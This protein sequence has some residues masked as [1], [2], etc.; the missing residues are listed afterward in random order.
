MPQSDGIQLDLFTN[1]AQDESTNNIKAIDDWITPQRD[2][3][4]RIANIQ[5]QRKRSVTCKITLNLAEN[6]RSEIK[7]KLGDDAEFTI[8]TE[9]L[10]RQINGVYWLANGARL[11]LINEDGALINFVAADIEFVASRYGNVTDDAELNRLAEVVAS[12]KNL[13]ESKKEKFIGTI[14]KISEKKIINH[15]K[16]YNQRTQLKIEIDMFA[17]E[18]Y[19]S[20]HADY[21]TVHFTHLD[22]QT[23]LRSYNNE[24]IDDYKSHFKELD[25]VLS[26]IIASRF[27]TDRKKSFLWL[28]CDSDWGK[29]LLISMLSSIGMLTTTST[30]EVEKM[31]SGGPVAKSIESFKRS[32]ILSIDEFKNVKSEIKQLCS[33]IEISP[34]MQLSTTVPLYYKLFTSAES[35]TS[36]ANEN[37][38]EDQF[39]NRFAYIEGT[40]SIEKRLVW[41]EFGKFEYA[42]H[43]Q[44]YIAHTFNRM[45][46][47]YR[48]LG[49]EAASKKADK[50][51]DEFHAKYRIDKHYQRFSTS[52]ESVAAEI[53]DWL[54]N[55][56]D[57][58]RYINHR[59]TN[60]VF[61]HKG[62]YYVKSVSKVLDTA[63]NELYERSQI[64]ALN[65]KKEDLIKLLST[66]TLIKTR[67]ISSKKIKCIQL[68]LHS[69]FNLSEHND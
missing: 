25:D 11:N 47:E 56:S 14:G 43:V 39:A 57:D 45:I 61:I 6:I 36:L 38:I 5:L 8:N 32:L 26:S 24:I 69:E 65:K 37:G 17:D 41:I 50:I 27:A 4:P 33:E 64:G 7:K 28:K 13:T 20:L 16:Y 30:S 62:N 63:I 34:K 3:I 12:S 49:K 1:P 2:L 55:D 10:H 52:L 51:A 42:A 19:I 29:G 59:A 60:F 31:L 23:P 48:G 67:S 21:V 68:R 53:S 35:V 46:N 54:V 66:D 22:Y 40:G 15:I 9:N 58:N 44:T 18:S